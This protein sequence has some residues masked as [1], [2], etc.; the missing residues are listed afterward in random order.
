MMDD[1]R[2]QAIIA[3]NA[4]RTPGTW[5]WVEDGGRASGWGHQGPDL[6]TDSTER[7]FPYTTTPDQR[8][9]SSWGY[10][11]DGLDVRDEDAEFIAYASNDIPDLLDA[12]LDARK[13][14]ARLT[15]ALEQEEK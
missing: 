13:E 6:C 14:I 8:I 3:R 12:L 9:I 7:K 10:D 11:A 15:R 4:A 2:L 5:S 1:A